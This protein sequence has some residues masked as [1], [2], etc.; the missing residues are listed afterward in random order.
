MPDDLPPLPE[1]DRPPFRLL[2]WLAKWLVL[3]LSCATVAAS[4]FAFCDQHHWSARMVTPFRPQ[5]MLLGLGLAAAAWWLRSGWPTRFVALAAV[6]VNLW[7]IWP[8]LTPHSGARPDATFTL[9][10]WNTWRDHPDPLAAIAAVRDSGV[11]VALL[12]ELPDELREQ[13][14]LDIPGYQ[15]RVHDEYAVAVRNGGPVELLTSGLPRPPNCLA[16]V[17]RFQQQEIRL[18]CSHDTRPTSSFGC[19]CQDYRTQ[20]VKQWLEASPLPAVLVGDCNQTP[21]CPRLSEFVA[22]TGLRDTSLQRGLTY[23]YPGD[24][25]I[26]GRLIGI[27]IDQCLLTTDLACESTWVGD[28]AGS[29]HRPLRATIG[30]APP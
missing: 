9:L 13:Q 18:L 6:A 7:V 27:P 23:T 22:Q 10:S 25:P 21:W 12:C 26:V 14:R 16:A 28:A 19:H 15:T 4:V 24:V 2:P 5:L 20:V 11:D 17:V 3:L 29:N 30:F 8:W 1:P